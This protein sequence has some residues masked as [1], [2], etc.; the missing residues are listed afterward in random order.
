MAWCG[1]VVCVVLWSPHLSWC[2]QLISGKTPT[3]MYAQKSIAYLWKMHIKPRSKCWRLLVNLGEMLAMD[4]FLELR[5]LCSGGIH[6]IWTVYMYMGWTVML[7]PPRDMY[8]HIWQSHIEN[9][10]AQPKISS[11]IRWYL[12]KRLYC[13]ELCRDTVTGRS[14]GR[15]WLMQPISNRSSPR[16]SIVQHSCCHINNS[17]KLQDFSELSPSAD[18]CVTSPPVQASKSCKLNW[19]D[20]WNYVK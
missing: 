4:M 2:Q 13:E 9:L 10:L 5:T 14:P 20:I 19:L 1:A 15:A 16:S 11:I 7:A 18:S 8:I 6:I 17:Q 3:Q 12:S